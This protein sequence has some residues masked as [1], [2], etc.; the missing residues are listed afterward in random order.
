M[1]SVVGVQGGES[2]VFDSNC[3]GKMRRD[4]EIDDES[5]RQPAAL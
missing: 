1:K 5:A 3:D 4:E 2:G